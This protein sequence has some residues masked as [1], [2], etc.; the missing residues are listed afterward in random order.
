[1]SKR[2]SELE[3][4]AKEASERA[5]KLK[6]EERETILEHP[7]L[8]NYTPTMNFLKQIVG[9]P[10]LPGFKESKIELMV[11]EVYDKIEA[12]YKDDWESYQRTKVAQRVAVE[13]AEGAMNKAN[14]EWL[15]AK[16]A[17][18]EH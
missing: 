12:E 13:E 5:K 18:E 6:L 11:K 9:Y 3:E 2:I 17:A 1:M 15:A 4:K 7:E 10:K 16:R 14:R 8:E